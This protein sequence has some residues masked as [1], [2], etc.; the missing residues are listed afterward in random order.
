MCPSL[1]QQTKSIITKEEAGDPQTP[2]GQW[3]A[4]EVTSDTH[5]AAEDQG[6]TTFYK[7]M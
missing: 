3:L 5:H 7:E 2:E 4:L 1:K 6:E